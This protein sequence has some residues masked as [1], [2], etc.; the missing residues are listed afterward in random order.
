MATILPNP[1]WPVLD[2][3]VDNTAGPPSIPGAN[4]QS[5]QRPGLGVTQLSTIRGRQYEQGRCEAGTASVKVLDP[6]EQLNPRNTSSVFNTGG[7]SILPYRGVQIPV[8]WPVG[9]GTGNILNSG[10]RAAYDP[11]FESSAG[12]NPGSWA[13]AGG[14]TTCVA[15]TAQHFQGS[16]SMLVTQS[17]AGAGF[18]AVVTLQHVPRFT[19]VFS[20]YVYPTGGCSVQIQI[21]LGDGSTVSSSTASTQNA[22]TR[23]QVSWLAVDTFETVTVYGTGTSTPTWYLDA[24]QL[25]W[26]SAA[27]AF[28]TSG[29]TQYNIYTGFVERWPQTWTD[30]GFRGVRPLECVD[31][32]GPLSRAIV[33]QSYMS[34]ISA[35]APALFLPLTD[36]TGPGEFTIGGKYWGIDNSPSATGQF[37][38]GSDQFLNGDPAMTMSQRNPASPAE[39]GTLDG[40]QITE[41][42]ILSGT[43]TINTT[44]VTIEVWAKFD[45][46]N[47][48]PLQIGVITDGVTVAP[49]Q[50]YVQITSRQTGVLQTGLRD[51]VSPTGPGYLQF[52]PGFGYADGLWHYY[53]VTLTPASGNTVVTQADLSFPG[54]GVISPALQNPW[55]INNIHFDCSTDLGDA[56]SQMSLYGFALYTRDI[57]ATARNNHYLRG[58]GYLGEISGTR[59]AR[60]CTSYWGGATSIATGFAAIA[61]DYNYNGRNVLD[62]MYEITDTEAGLLYA[63]RNGVIVF[64]DRSTRYASQTST[65]TFGTGVSELHYENLEYDYDP[66][67]VYSQVDLTRPGNANYPPKS[68]STSLATYGQRVLNTELQLTSDFDLDQAA[69]YLLQRYGTAQPRIRKLTLNPAG[70]AAIWATVLGLEIS[71]RITLNHR[72]NGVTMAGD[73]YVEKIQHTVN[74]ES[75]PPSWTVDLQLSPVFVPS[76]WVLGDSTFGVLGTTT[77]PVY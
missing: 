7:R 2:V 28:T 11:G 68:S 57:G 12:S 54:A 69:L 65:A 31:A 66:T 52:R 77:V 6:Q 21:T 32:F 34:T 25:E 15:S 67:Y 59:I 39:P 19:Y 13:P 18:G 76:A 44:A 17:A 64:E 70:N 33:H 50:Q 53:V 37:S 10:V 41:W 42:N 23:L 73:Y 22:W 4:R 56:L 40:T 9:A 27:S 26:G 71:Q 24:Y 43:L 5:L 36:K 51:N 75:S 49:D 16:K 46:G 48:T 8:L 62:V 74:M 30:N 29:P 20:C 1:A 35:D 14:T 55:G 60:L 3:Q 45:S 63:N 38:W 58:A 72:V 61:E 47:V